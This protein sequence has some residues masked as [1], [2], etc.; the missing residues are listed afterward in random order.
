MRSS[1]IASTTLGTPVRTHEAD[2]V[3]VILSYLGLPQSSIE[4][5]AITGLNKSAISELL[6]GHRVRDTKQRRHIAIVAELIRALRGARAASTGRSERGASALG[7]LHSA[8]VRTSRGM[9]NPLQ[10][11]SDTDLAVEALDRLS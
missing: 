4:A 11:L 9:R 7:W 2:D 1:T 6:N 10:I 5:Q 8:R 3:R